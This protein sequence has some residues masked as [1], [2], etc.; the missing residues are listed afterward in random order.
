MQAPPECGAISGRRARARRLVAAIEAVV[1]FG[2][3][4]P[5]A[6]VR[7]PLLGYI[8]LTAYLRTRAEL[9]A[10]TASRRRVRVAVA[11]IFMAP[12]LALWIW[13]VVWAAHLAP[14]VLGA[15][16]IG[17]L[18]LAIVRQRRPRLKK[19]LPATAPVTGLFVLACIISFLGYVDD[20][21]STL[22][23]GVQ[24]G[25]D[26]EVVTWF[27]AHVRDGRC[28]DEPD[29]APGPILACRDPR[30]VLTLRAGATA[31]LSCGS[32]F[33]AGP[34]EPVVHVVRLADGQPLASAPGGVAAWMSTVGSDAVVLT[35]TH[36]DHVSLL[37]LPGL[38]PLA[39]RALLHPVAGLETEDGLILAAGETVQDLWLLDAVSL[40]DV[41]PPT[42][43]QGDPMA[44][45]EVHDLIALP[46]HDLL[47]GSLPVG[48][49]S[50]GTWEL[51]TLRWR[52]ARPL[53][54]GVRDLLL[55]PDRDQLLAAVPFLGQVVVLDVPELTVRRRLRAGFSATSLA[56]AGDSVVVGSYFDGWLRRFAWPEG[57]PAGRVWL[58]R[59]IRDVTPVPGTQDLLAV[60]RCG[61]FRVKP[62]AFEAAP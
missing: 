28:V 22:C 44:A 57:S 9:P 26:I 36:R 11:A 48:I 7:P 58:G 53:G 49:G 39:S 24:P 41:R 10:P 6:V 61:L 19:V 52:A 47:V 34:S 42:G 20:R 55:L 16:A 27:C 13:P 33:G 3:I 51:S 43:R 38:E 60:S 45:W 21:P 17:A 25:G 8:A 18:T 12:A 40:E 30:R 2:P 46:E 1:S 14:A 32:T 29:R 31:V 35:H 62:E 4:L 37:S 50:L 56:W 23:G 5:G 54:P 15:G 59:K